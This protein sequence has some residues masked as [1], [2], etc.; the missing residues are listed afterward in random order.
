VEGRRA[1]GWC[2]CVCVCVG[3]GVQW[4]QECSRCTNTD[5]GDE[6][7]LPLVK[8]QVGAA[9]VPL[10]TLRTA[11][12]ARLGTLLSH[13]HVK[14]GRQQ[15]QLPEIERALLQIVEEGGGAAVARKNR[16]KGTCHHKQTSKGVG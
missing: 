5:L 9:R 15:H 1:S 14:P 2:A 7:L 8:V 4:R 6:A 16:W 12:S 11:P 13:Y 3:G 10:H